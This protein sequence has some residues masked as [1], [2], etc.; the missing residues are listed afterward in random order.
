MSMERQLNL[1][2]EGITCTGCAMDM[3]N[4]LQDMDGVLEAVVRYAEGA[5]FIRFDPEEVDRK[6]LLSKV[7]SFG[8]PFKERA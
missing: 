3:E 2:L 4:V 7:A 5:I 1:Q 8:F 6:S